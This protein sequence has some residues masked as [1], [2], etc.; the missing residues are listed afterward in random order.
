MMQPDGEWRTAAR[1]ATGAELS[2]E[3]DSQVADHPLHL[4]VRISLAWLG[5][6]GSKA[7][8]DEAD[9]FPLLAHP[10]S[11]R[12]SPAFSPLTRPKNSTI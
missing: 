9:R 1:L 3:P 12:L 8:K 5:Q 4:H 7:T 6:Q 2:C 11:I 10:P